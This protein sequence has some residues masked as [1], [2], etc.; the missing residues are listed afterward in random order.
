MSKQVAEDRF[1]RSTPVISGNI[2]LPQVYKNGKKFIQNPQRKSSSTKTNIIKK[3]KTIFFFMNPYEDSQFSSFTEK[4]INFFFL[5]L[6][7]YLDCNFSKN[8]LFFYKS[9]PRLQL[10]LFPFL[11]PCQIEA[12]KKNT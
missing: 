1:Q 3:N 4:G 8:Q 9:L 5:L 2:G 10:L 7:R 12:M 11:S 6:N